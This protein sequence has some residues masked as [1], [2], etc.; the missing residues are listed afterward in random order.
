MRVDLQIELEQLP[1]RA[2]LKLVGLL[3]VEVQK[4][5]TQAIAPAPL[6]GDVVIHPRAGMAHRRERAAALAPVVVV[7]ADHVGAPSALGDVRPLRLLRP[8]PSHPPLAGTEPRHALHTCVL[9]GLK[10][11]ARAPKLRAASACG[12]GAETAPHKSASAPPKT[13]DLQ[14]KWPWGP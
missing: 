10:I 11:I 5:A 2:R 1:D 8:G 9:L 4:K 7:E 3:G 13:D 14:G 12:K 6:G